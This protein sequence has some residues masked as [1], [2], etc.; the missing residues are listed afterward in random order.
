MICKKIKKKGILKLAVMLVV[1][2]NFAC[3]NVFANSDDFSYIN[4]SQTTKSTKLINPIRLD[5]TQTTK[6]TPNTNTINT[7]KLREFNEADYFSSLNSRNL[8]V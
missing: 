4:F 2:A 5:T 3:N 8:K 6:T 7:F 1:S